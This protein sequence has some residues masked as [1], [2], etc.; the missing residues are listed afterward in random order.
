MSSKSVKRISECFIKSLH[1][2][3]PEAKQPFHFTPF[4]LPCLNISY[5]QKGLLFAKPP[6]SESQDFSIT[7]YLDDLR[8]SLSATLDHFYPLAGR[9]VTKKE[10]NPASYVIYLDPE[11]SPGV[12]FIY[13][14]VDATISDILQPADVPVVV[15]SFFDLNNAIS[16]DGHTLPLL[17]IQVTELVDGIFIG[18]SINHMVA[19]GTSFWHFMGAWSEI[20]KSKEQSRCSISRPPVLKRWILDGSD[21]IINLPYTHHD[22]FIDRLEVPPF[23]ERFFHFSS[24]SVSKLKAKANSEYNTTKI[25]SLQA[26]IALLWR[27]VTRIRRLPDD[28]QT[29]C[30]LMISNR[31]RLNPPLSDDYFG[32]PI[33]MVRGTATVGELMANGLGWAAFRLHEA[34]IN[35]TDTSVKESVKSWI[36]NPFIIKLSKMIDRNFIHVGSS[37]RFDMYGCEFGLGK[38][39][40]ARSGW[41]NKGDGKITMYPGREGGGSMD[42]EICFASS[43]TMMDLECDEE[44]IDALKIER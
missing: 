31:R 42:V 36:E 27:S 29:S 2:L 7:A 23:I 34:V 13:A 3:S 6:P 1:D 18:G 16:H 19:D 5:S 22:Q 11:N 32:N 26:V 28:S 38:A 9:L 30:R 10:E 20:F 25:S 41:L 4:E 15:R 24:A 12:K 44:F 39:V 33:S 43:Q 17:S 8:R 35:Y 14:T 40:A 21:P 37:P